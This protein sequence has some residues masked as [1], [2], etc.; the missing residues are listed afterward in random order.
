MTKHKLGIVCMISGILLVLGAVYLLMIN[1]QEEFYARKATESVMPVLV[2][3]IQENTEETLPA[4]EIIPE[5][6]KPVALLTEE[7]KRMKEVVIDGIPYVGYLS[8]PK[9]DLNLPVIGTWSYPM[10]K[11]APCRYFG[12]VLDEN[13]VVMAHSYA[14]HFGNIAQLETGDSVIFTDMDGEVTCYE[15]VAED[16]LEPS[17]IE[18]MTAGVFDLTLFTC[19]YSGKHRITV[20]CDR[21]DA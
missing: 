17:A 8:I 9:L 13:L 5:P 20:Y 4:S 3:Q 6:H 2:Q 14:S 7:E 12:T 21:I 11:V 15:V 16:I 10:L 19:T 18:E 1:Q